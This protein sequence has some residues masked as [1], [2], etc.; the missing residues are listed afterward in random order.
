VNIKNIVG[1]CFTA[2]K[3][4]VKKTYVA[5]GLGVA[6][7]A[8][9]VSAQAQ[10]AT[11]PDPSAIYEDLATPFSSALTWVIGAIAVLAVIGWIRKAIRK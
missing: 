6:A 3:N 11:Y 5:L 1:R 2:A 7:V 4:L 8:S 9:T 10:T